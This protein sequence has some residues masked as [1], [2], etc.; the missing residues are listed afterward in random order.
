MR[1]FA[2]TALFRRVTDITPEYLH[3]HGIRALILDVDNT[4]TAHGSQELPGDVEA[5]LQ[6]MRKEG[7]RLVIASNNMPK[8]VAPFAKRVGLAYQA[9][10]CKPSPLGLARARRAMGVPRS[11]VALV[12]D[13]IF[14]DS[15]GAN[16]Y[17][18][19]MLLVRPMQKDTKPTIRL[20]RMLE[21][22]ILARYDQNGGPRYGWE[23]E[24]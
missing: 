13:Q 20:K 23:K 4:L 5:W 9:F 19:P 21:K 22:P 8:R 3:G 7:I 24:G 11:A 2:P 17:G 1:L 10:C 18:I 6:Q 14:T 16:L 15:L 12:G